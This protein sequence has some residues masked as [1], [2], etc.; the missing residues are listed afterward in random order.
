MGRKSTKG[1][2]QPVFYVEKPLKK[3]SKASKK[4]E[5]DNVKPARAKQTATKNTSATPRVGQKRGGSND[6]P[7]QGTPTPADQTDTTAQRKEATQAH[8][9]PSTRGD[10]KEEPQNHGDRQG[11]TAKADQQ[12][13]DQETSEPSRAQNDQGQAGGKDHEEGEGRQAPVLDERAQKLEAARQRAVEVRKSKA[14][15]RRAAKE[16]EREAQERGVKQAQEK[17]ERLGKVFPMDKIPTGPVPPP[18]PT[19]QVDPGLIPDPLPKKPPPKFLS[20]DTTDVPPVQREFKTPKETAFPVADVDTLPLL[21]RRKVDPEI[22]SPIPDE[23]PAP[24]QPVNAIMDVDDEDEKYLKKKRRELEKKRLLREEM[25]LDMAL[26]RS[27]MVPAPRQLHEDR[28]PPRKSAWDREHEERVKK[29]MTDDPF[30]KQQ[31]ENLKKKMLME[32]IFGSK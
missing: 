15:A 28:G 6:S 11:E 4:Y 20:G 23:Q 22:N 29:S 3:T 14:A 16:A 31:M 12:G 7:K 30:L 17:K 18:P 25:E 9:T 10:G 24:P 1:S 21:K 2:E 19:T 26:N 5:P 27:L 8:A 32:A 13:R